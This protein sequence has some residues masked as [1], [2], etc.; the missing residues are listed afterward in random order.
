MGNQPRETSSRLELGRPKEGWTSGILG[1][2]VQS[3]PFDLLV[4]PVWSS[5]SHGPERLTFYFSVLWAS[6]LGVAGS[7]PG[8]SKAA[9]G[10]SD[11]GREPPKKEN[12]RDAGGG[13]AFSRC[14]ET[15]QPGAWATSM[16]LLVV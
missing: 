2:V 5:F 7:K 11:L 1:S 3:Q 8:S 16:L 15:P 13:G 9:W 12:A 6:E 4:F 14:G 10:A